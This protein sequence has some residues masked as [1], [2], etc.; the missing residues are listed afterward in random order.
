MM[1]SKCGKDTRVLNTVS[2]GEKVYRHRKCKECSHSFY[3]TEEVSNCKFTLLELR[4]K[5]R[6]ERGLKIKGMDT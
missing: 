3:T 1:C 6:K 4:D 2:D 5:Q